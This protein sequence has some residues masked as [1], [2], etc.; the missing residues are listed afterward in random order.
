MA[1]LCWFVSPEHVSAQTQQAS[2]AIATRGNA[3]EVLEVTT[4]LECSSLESQGLLHIHVQS[5]A[6]PSV[7][8]R[9]LEIVFTVAH[10]P[11]G[12][13]PLLIAG[14]YRSKRALRPLTAR[15]RF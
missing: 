10:S 7:R 1:L 8:D 12:S 3:N 4:L 6:G 11:E 15:F 2:C 13:Y 14:P 9:E 5:A